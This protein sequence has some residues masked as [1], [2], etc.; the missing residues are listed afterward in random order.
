MGKRIKMSNGRRLVGDVIEMANKMPLA[1]FSGD[2]D[3]GIV[4]SFRRQTRPK[5]SWNVLYMK[6]YAAVCKNNPELR[7][8]Y[9]SF[10][11]GHFYEHGPVVCLMTIAREYQGEERLF[12][13]RFNRPDEKSL[14]DLQERYDYYR[15]APIEEVKQFRHQIM[16]ARM[17]KPVRRLGWWVMNGLWPQKR[18]SHMGTFGISFSGYKG[19]YGT[20]HLGTNSTILGVDPLPRKGVSRLLLTFDHRVMDGTPVTRFMQELQHLMTTSIRVELA[21][22]IGVDPSTGEKLTEEE[23]AALNRRL[24]D[25]RMEAS[26]KR[27]AA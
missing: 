21:E 24:D 23:L 16:F 3:T 14:A 4:H 5:V 18:A 7:R 19:V 27:A 8:S 15:Q 10:P 17:P 12:F 6:A 2:F 9:V 25:G 13:A 26:H 11:W 20:Q 22:M 1:A